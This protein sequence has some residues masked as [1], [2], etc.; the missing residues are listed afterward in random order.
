M[1]GTAGLLE[2]KRKYYNESLADLLL[3]RMDLYRIVKVNG[4]LVRKM[5]PVYMYPVMKNGRA[6]F[7]ASVK[8][9]GNFYMSTV[10]FNILALLLMCILFYLTL[11]FSIL[12][13][14]LDMLGG[15]KRRKGRSSVSTA[16]DGG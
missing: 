6:Q 10:L 8:R 13:K 5:E 2:F 16:A 9:I 15:K 1:G 12:R 14:T 11:Q 7:F 4:K 3:N